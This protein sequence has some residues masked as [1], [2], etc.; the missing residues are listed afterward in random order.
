MVVIVDANKF[1][2]NLRRFTPSG[3]CQQLT[4]TG[5]F[6]EPWEQWESGWASVRPDS[7]P[8]LVRVVG[9][10][11][12]RETRTVT[13]TDRRQ[14]PMTWVSRETLPPRLCIQVECPEKIG[15]HLMAFSIAEEVKHD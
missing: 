1:P 13:H 8:R 11:E 10:E 9:T 7:D 14:D 5:N 4:V 3:A 15:E 6:T 2:I 12:K